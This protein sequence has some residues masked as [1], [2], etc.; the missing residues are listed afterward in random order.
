MLP[1]INNYLPLFNFVIASSALIFQTTVLYPWHKDI[2]KQIDKMDKKIYKIDKKIDSKMN[3]KKKFEPN[4]I[5][6]FA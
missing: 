3:K 4:I 2:S 6:T 1:R 5:T